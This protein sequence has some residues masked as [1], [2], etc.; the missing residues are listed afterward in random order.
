MPPFSLSDDELDQVMN[1]A[2]AVPVEQRDAF[3]QS[4]AEAVGKYPEGSRGPGLIRRE[5]YAPCS[6]IP[7]TR[8]SR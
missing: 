5:A 3:L 2:Q 7:S 8:R 4:V 1:L 6:A